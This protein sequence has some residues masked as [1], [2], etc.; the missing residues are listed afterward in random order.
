MRFPRLFV[1]LAFV[2]VLVAGCSSSGSFSYTGNW[3]GNINDSVAGAGT[4]T[5]S[6]TQSGSTFVGTWQA[7]FSSGSNGGSLTGTINGSSVVVDLEPSNASA[8]P[9]NVVAQRA[10]SQISGNYSAYN[11]TGTITGTLTITKQ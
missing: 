2:T 7:V 4:M 6:L 1:S 5:A 10:G 11:C 3:A 9:Y 8:C